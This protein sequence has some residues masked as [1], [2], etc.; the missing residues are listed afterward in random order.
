M[1]P[2]GPSGLWMSMVLLTTWPAFAHRPYDRAAGTF[3]RPDGKT[4]SIVRH[5][6]D[7]I[8]FADPVSI[9]FRLPDGTNVASTHFV[10]DAVVRAVPAAVEVFQFSSTW[11]PIAGRVD[12]FDGY[13]LQDITSERR[14]ISPWVHLAG[15]WV[16]YLVVFGV[17][18]IFVALLLALRRIPNRGWRIALRWIGFALV[19]LAGSF[20][21]CGILVFEPVSP[22]ILALAGVVFMAAFG[23]IRKRRHA[24]PS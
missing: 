6:V 17:G 11:V 16:E 14:F 4:V 21:A 15:H 7:G 24:T 2:F 8:F 18:M 22:L 5:Y 20:F 13:A 3:K 9:Q 12:R 10:C 1:R 19:G 23:F